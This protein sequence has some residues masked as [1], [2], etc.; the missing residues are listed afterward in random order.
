MKHYS[1]SRYTLT[2]VEPTIFNLIPSKKG[3]ASLMFYNNSKSVFGSSRTESYHFLIQFFQK[4]LFDC[5]FF[6]ETMLLWIFEI[7]LTQW[8]RQTFLLLKCDMHPRRFWIL[9]SI[10]RPR[11]TRQYY[12][13]ISFLL[14]S[15][16]FS[17]HFGRPVTHYWDGPYSYNYIN[18]ST[19]WSNANY[20]H[21]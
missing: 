21:L 16:L 11:S 4:R 10:Q 6:F 1:L 5:K 19:R 12:F 18:R 14:V 13:E 3:M 7:F 8:L 2:A 15:I 20:F 9:C 17:C